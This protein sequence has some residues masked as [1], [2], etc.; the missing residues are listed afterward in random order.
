MSGINQQ[1]PLGEVRS[2]RSEDIFWSWPAT[3]PPARRV[4]G[5][6]RAPATLVDAT[7]YATADA[8]SIPAVSTSQRIR[9]A[10][11]IGGGSAFGSRVITRDGH[12]PA[13]ANS[14]EFR[15]RRPHG[16]LAEGRREL[17]M[18]A[19]SRGVPGPEL[20]LRGAQKSFRTLLQRA[21]RPVPTGSMIPSSRSLASVLLIC[22]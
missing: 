11:V 13:S 14:T 22:D 12:R 4:E 10:P 20:G 1:A 17:V 2:S 7:F 5:E 8:G 21:F 18:L 16:D 19:G 15:A 3:T 6:I 9:T